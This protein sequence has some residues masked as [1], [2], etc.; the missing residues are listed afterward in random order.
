MLHAHPITIARHDE[1]M[2]PQRPQRRPRTR[3]SNHWKERIKN[4]QRLENAP[5]LSIHPSDSS[6]I[7]T[8]PVISPHERRHSDVDIGPCVSYHAVMVRVDFEQVRRF[9]ELLPALGDVNPFDFCAGGKT[10]LFPAPGAPGA[11]EFFF[12]NAAHQFGFWTESGGRYD[13]PMIAT[14]GGKARKGSDYLFYCF[15]RALDRDADC[16]TPERLDALSDDELDAL[17]R[18]D[19]GRNPLPMWPEHLRIIRAYARWF[20]DESTSPRAVVEESNAAPRPLAAFLERA[21]QVPGYRE[22]P[23]QKKLMLL[24][25]ILENRPEHFLRVTDPESGV[26]I[27]DYHLQRSA[28]RTGLVVID[29]PVLRGKNVNRERV[30][31]TEEARIR[32]ATYE[33]IEQLVAQSGLSVAAVDYFFFTNRTR[34]PEMS[35]PQCA[36]CPVQPICAQSTELFQ[37][38]FRTEAY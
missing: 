27:I 1:G 37:P 4:F 15:Q 32:Q 13:R 17:F 5:S 6:H 10:E 22:D 2:K 12:L 7:C 26:P 11:L 28:L 19:T 29:D 23:L 35:A 30:M 9:A 21:G 20:I 31:P 33:A 3:L 16:Y 36:V 14:V 8:P 18:D 25:V 38:V 24:A 34:C